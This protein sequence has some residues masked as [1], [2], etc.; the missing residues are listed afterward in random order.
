MIF[1]AVLLSAAC[2]GRDEEPASRDGAGMT[3]E[4]GEE[5]EYLVRVGDRSLTEQDFKRLV[6]AEF[7][8]LL[9]QEEKRDFLDR[10]V[11]TE[12]LYSAAQARGLNE[13]PELKG[14]LEQQKREFIANQLLQRVLQERVAVSEREIADYYSIHLDE[15]SSE[16]RYSEIIVR[17]REEAQ[18]L[19][20]KLQS[21]SFPFAR[22]AGQSSIASSASSGGDMGWLAKGAMP[23][24]VEERAVKMAPMEISEP[25]ETAWGW[26]II[27]FVEKR[28]S[29][30]PLNLFE[31]RDEIL[32][33]LTMTRRRQVYRDYLQELQASYPVAYHPQL[34]ERLHSGGAAPDPGSE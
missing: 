26:T 20:D 21:R 15:Y 34:G 3:A 28:P 7:E 31:V 22:A 30:D 4:G 29:K 32:R 14:R 6:P 13:D 11:D 23:A 8:S 16:Y 10:W 12:L 19:W 25:F 18:A 9:T 33:Y 27:Q 17:T 5:L 1:L 2:G 24:E